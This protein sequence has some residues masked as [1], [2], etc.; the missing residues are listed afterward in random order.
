[1]ARG[2][3][4]CS[5][6]LF[7]TIVLHQASGGGV[8]KSGVWRHLWARR[9]G[10]PAPEADS[11]K[12]AAMAAAAL[13]TSAGEGLPRRSGWLR[14][15]D[16]CCWLLPVCSVL[17][18]LIVYALSPGLY[19][20]YFLQPFQR[21]FQVVELVTFGSALAAAAIL[22][23]S[24]AVLWRRDRLR[25]RI[26][27]LP[28]GALLIALLAMASLFF[29]GEE[30]SWGQSWFGWDSP[31]AF[32]DHQ[33]LGET[34]LHNIEHM[35]FSIQTLGSAFLMALLVVL[36]L[37]WASRGA[38]RR[39]GIELP[40]DWAPAIAEWPVVVVTIFAFV[41]GWSKGLYVAV[42]GRDPIDDEQ[43]VP[44]FSDMLARYRRPLIASPFYMQFVEQVNEQKEMLV[45][46]ALLVYALYRVI[47]TRSGNAD[48][49]A[50]GS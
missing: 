15:L 6:A 27:N 4:W 50:R 17:V 36:P 2:N 19:L 24:A 45:A 28:G 1:M 41:W 20:R 7:I 35:P 47:A 12:M 49:V 44:W 42:V 40:E 48:H 29:A 16:T 32:L 26:R 23:W 18:L 22:G 33:G 11:V 38:L 5:V 39:R 25:G 37:L 30:I 3:G 10:P 9:G 13:T 46:M 43:L 34:N 31:D 14:V 8:F 21:E